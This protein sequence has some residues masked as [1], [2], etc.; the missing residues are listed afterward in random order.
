M[1]KAMKDATKLTQLGREPVN[2]P[3]TVNVPMHRA[4]TVLFESL[5][6]LHATQR[7]FDQDEQIPTYGI[8]NM[9][10][11]LALE[12][13]VAEIEHGY[14]AM[15]YPSGMAAVAGALLACVK[16]GDHLLMTDSGYGPT[17]QFCDGYLKRMQVE[18]TYYDPLIGGDIAA[19]IRPNTTVI[20]TESPG[21][22][23]FDVQDIP[24]IAAAGKAKH[25]RIIMDNAWATGLYFDAFKHG[26][27]L[28]V[29]PATKYYA[30][31][32]DVLIGLVIAN[33]QSWPQLK[34]TAYAMGQRASPDDCFLTLRGM[35]TMGVR[36]EKHAQSALKIARWLEKQSEVAHVLYPA[37]ET[38]PGHALWKR[39]FT[40]ASGV[41][42]VELKPC[43]Q[44]QVAAM[45][46][47]YQYF[48]MG[49]S[50]GGFESLVV[51]AYLM[52]RNKPWQ[53]GPLLRYQIGLEDADDLIADLEAGFARLNV[54]A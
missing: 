25:A 22:L 39:D 13:A 11:S 4:S 41:F 27:D 34:D 12:N 33:K 30:G 29:Q 2:Q 1:K 43:T 21:S 9:P 54:A 15:S 47:H 48:A 18:T 35:R 38:D 36:L 3:M 24:A 45:L 50:W 8:F 19:L 16:P 7:R 10:Q 28:V 20:Y 17:R 26:V 53:G 6:D 44:I 37:L 51:P 14:R 49:Y 5:D 31:H 32:S 42:G 40:G 23:T 46:D 52:Q